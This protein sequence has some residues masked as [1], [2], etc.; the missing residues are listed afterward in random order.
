MEKTWNYIF[1]ISGLMLVF[2]FTGLST[3]SGTILSFLLNIQNV[4]TTLWWTTVSGILA[5]TSAATIIVGYFSKN[6]ELA[7]VA[8]LASFLLVSLFDF[9][10]IYI[11][12][13]ELNLVM[14]TLFFAPFMLLIPITIV[15]YW[16]GR[17]I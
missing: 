14:A 9:L 6:V 12:L 16:R 4:N 10:K 15:E 2:Y 7:L 3:T 11:F 17:D 5:G 13:A 8:P 1:I